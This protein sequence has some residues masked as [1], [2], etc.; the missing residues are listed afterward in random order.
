MRES[1]EELLAEYGMYEVLAVTPTASEA[2]RTWLVSTRQGDLVVKRSPRGSTAPRTQAGLLALAARHPGLP[3]PLLLTSAVTGTALSAD[4]T[5]YVTTRCP[6]RPLEAA[7]VTDGLVSALARHQGALMDALADADADALGVPGV[8]A[9]SL[10]AVP[11][12][13]PLVDTHAPAGTAGFLRAVIDDYRTTVAP[14]RA[15]L[16]VQVIH[17]DLNL[18]NVLVSDDGRVTGIIDFGDAVLAP[19]VYDVAVTACYL[20]LAHGALDHP[21]VR[22]YLDRAAIRCRL[23][24]GEIPLLRTLVLCRLVIVILLSRESARRSP[25]RAGYVLRYDH[26]AERLLARVIDIEAQKGTPA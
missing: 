21:V 9:W 11:D 12:Y 24:A 5:A 7:T 17:A 10:D 13:A 3:L 2:D 16:P 20:A 6:G 26:L 1:V 23:G 14:A 22:T 8:N 15:Q 19:R 25:D 4:G 18:S